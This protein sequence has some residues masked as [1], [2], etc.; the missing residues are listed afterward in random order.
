MVA[1]H[2]C[3]NPLV[4]VIK[5]KL[6]ELEDESGGNLDIVKLKAHKKKGLLFALPNLTRCNQYSIYYYSNYKKG[7]YLQWPA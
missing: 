6:T 7:I 2:E 3:L 5:D 4:K 1:P